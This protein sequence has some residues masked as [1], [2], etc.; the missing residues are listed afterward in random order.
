MNKNWE[1]LRKLAASLGM[2]TQKEFVAWIKSRLLEMKEKPKLRSA[3]GLGSALQRF[4]IKSSKS[5]DPEFDKAIREKQPQWFIDTAAE[6]K[7][8]L[9]SLPNGS[10]RPNR[11]TSPL[12]IKLSVY[13]CKSHPTFDPEFDKAIRAKHPKWFA[14]YDEDRKKQLLDLP[15]GSPRPRR[16]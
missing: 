3:D 14:S 1:E 9:M 12:G 7:K 11:K 10:P 13:I 6:N 4:L 2:K 5:Y 15:K 8:K 16:K